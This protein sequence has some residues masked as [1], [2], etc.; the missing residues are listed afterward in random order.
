MVF[1]FVSGC[2]PS[3]SDGAEDSGERETVFDPMVQTLERAESVEAQSQDT[4]RPSWG[5]PW[6]RLLHRVSEMAL[7][8][9]LWDLRQAVVRKQTLRIHLPHL[10]IA[11]EYRGQMRPPSW[12]RGSVSRP[13]E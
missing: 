9:S 5:K 4:L 7:R 11:G 10:S 6:L 8:E 13:V 1:V 12:G 3:G 2:G